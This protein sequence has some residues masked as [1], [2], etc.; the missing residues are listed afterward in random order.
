M[1]GPGVWQIS[2]I[3]FFIIIPIIG[4]IFVAT[5]KSLNMTAKALWLIVV[6][7]FNILGLF[8]YLLSRV[9]T[10]ER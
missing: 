5:D 6:I 1:I 9:L 2:I 8:G 7:L 10:R 4:V 3:L